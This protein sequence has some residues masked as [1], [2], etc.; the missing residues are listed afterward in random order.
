M[1]KEILGIFLQSHCP[2]CDRN[3]PRI[4]CEDCQHQLN[5]HKRSNS[6]QFWSG[7]IPLLVW[8]NYE[9]QLK[10][11]I[12]TL[13]YENHPQLGEELG[14]WLGE[15]WLKSKVVSSEDNYTVIPIPLHPK[16]LQERGFN[17]AEVIA[18]GFCRVTRYPLLPQGLRRIRDTVKL[19]ELSPE[20]RQKN[21]ADTFRLGQDL[22]KNRTHSPILLIDD[23]Y[24][25]GTT[26]K[27]GVKVLRQ[28]HLQWLG[29]AAI[30]TSR[31]K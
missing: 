3:S 29:V 14:I 21:M 15:T 22:L 31:R 10:Q 7:E 25:T 20:E 23:I 5:Q 28:H 30:A 4:L 26:V 19:F 27:E 1:L 24:T 13:K 12:T 6:R 18:R 11:A 2:L 17:Q 16:R 8:G 9:G